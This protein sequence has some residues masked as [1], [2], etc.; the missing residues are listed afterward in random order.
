MCWRCAGTLARWGT[1]RLGDAQTPAQHVLHVI[2]ACVPIEI[3]V[4]CRSLTKHAIKMCLPMCFH[5]ASRLAPYSH[6]L[7]ANHNA[8]SS[9]GPAR[10]GDLDP[11]ASRWHSDVCLRNLTLQRQLPA[12]RQNRRSMPP[13]NRSPGMMSQMRTIFGYASGCKINEK[14]HARVRT[15]G[16]V[17]CIDDQHAGESSGR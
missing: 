9:T 15:A 8:N 17:H 13:I 11:D 4:R 12:Q 5:S 14:P 10:L 6:A 3:L 16:T 1:G 7:V 2:L